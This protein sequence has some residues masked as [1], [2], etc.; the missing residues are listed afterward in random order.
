MTF[1]TIRQYTVDLDKGVTRCVDL[2]TALLTEDQNAHTFC[3]ACFRGEQAV[4]LSGASVTGYCI[5]QD[6]ATVPVTGSCSANTAILTL[7]EACYAVPGS[8]SLVIKLT[9]GSVISTIFWGHGIVGRSRTDMLV[10]AANVVPSLDELLAQISAMETA[11][12]RA[13]SA[14][15]AAEGT[16]NMTA[17][18]TSL[19]SGSQATAAYANG[20]LTIGIP[21][22]DKGDTGPTGPQG[23]K[24]EDG[25]MV[26]VSLESG[27]FAMHVDDEGHL[28]LTHNDN[29]PT[30]P[31]SI[32]SEGHMVYTIE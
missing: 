4:N 12:A 20:V 26:G 7:P 23:P 24:G 8:L 14:A 29:E 30:P 15:E 22:G 25:S 2:G 17:T 32:N 1:E 16:A 28:I 10:D 9:M 11:T 3:V 13:N 27:M 18:A 19:A 5:R 21:K 31:L 6:G